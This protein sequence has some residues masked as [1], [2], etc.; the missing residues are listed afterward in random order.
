[1]VKELAG[2]FDPGTRPE[3]VLFL[4]EASGVTARPWI[5]AGFATLCVDLA[6]DGQDVRLIRLPQLL[7]LLRRHCRRPFGLFAMP[8]C[9]HL[10][11]SGARWW[12]SKGSAALLEGLSVVD[13]CVRLADSLRPSG[14]IW[15]A[16]E[17]PVGR[18]TSFL[19]PPR[20]TFQ[21]C[22]YGDP[23]TKRT[24]LWGWGFSTDLPRT[25]VPPS[26]GS[27]MHRLPP[28]VNRPALRSVT[29]SGFSEAFFWANSQ[30]AG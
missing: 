16:L 3:A 26:Q 29:P 13:A 30:Q 9:T 25:P 2:R 17:N 5:A 8:P 23:Y 10:A 20:M 24:C 19:G 7:S 28:T 11:G 15:F 21:P 4:G 18:L 1:M 12:R 22:D 6:V 14:L 27:R